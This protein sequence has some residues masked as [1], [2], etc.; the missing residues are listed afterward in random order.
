[1]PAED[2]FDGIWDGKDE[3]LECQRNVRGR[4][5]KAR[6]RIGH[7]IVD[8]SNVLRI[9]KAKQFTLELRSPNTLFLAVFLRKRS[10][11][12]SALTSSH[13]HSQYLSKGL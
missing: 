6:K 3:R 8:T 2:S 9:V 10:I 11:L 7:A 5:M 4:T 12:Q 1:M 13:Y